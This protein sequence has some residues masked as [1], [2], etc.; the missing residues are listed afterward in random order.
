MDKEK[1]NTEI[2]DWS[3]AE[4]WLAELVEQTRVSA[5]RWFII[6]MILLAALVITNL[7]WIY[8]MNSYEYIY[9]NSSGQNNYNKNV[10]GDVENVATDK[11]EEE[12]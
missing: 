7:F 4:S 6:S 1:L 2:K 10:N 3:N 5:K 8:E 12:R 11:A 9:Q